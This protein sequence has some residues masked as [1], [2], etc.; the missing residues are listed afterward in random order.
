MTLLHRQSASKSYISNPGWG[1]LQQGVLPE[2]YYW[3]CKICYKR[4]VKRCAYSCGNGTSPP[5]KHLLQAHN[6]TVHGTGEKRSRLASSFAASSTKS[7]SHGQD[8][9]RFGTVFHHAAWKARVMAFICHDNRA[10]QMLE[11]SYFEDMLLS[12]NHSFGMRG[13]LPNYST[14][15]SW[16]ELAYTSHIGIVTELL[17]SAQ[18]KIQFSFNLWSSRNL[19]PLLDV[20]CHFANK[21]GNL[22]TFS[23]AL[24]EQSCPHLC[25][26]IA[27]NVAAIF[28]HYNVEHAPVIL[29]DLFSGCKRGTHL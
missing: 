10:F 27:D 21:F 19:R 7:S 23:L 12:F 16:I 1:V 24:P 8:I 26:N 13:C 3:I 25:V 14:I 5:T 6:N 4:K 2:V 11:S 20:K 17:H 18:S 29:F 15:C 28:R 9:E 22:K